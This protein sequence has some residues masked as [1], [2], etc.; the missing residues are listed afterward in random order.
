VA[1]DNARLYEQAEQAA[2]AAE[3][4]RLARDLHD[5]VTQTLFS[6]SLIADVLPRIWERDQAQ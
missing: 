1:V 4:N 2:V 5:A 3:R 6:A